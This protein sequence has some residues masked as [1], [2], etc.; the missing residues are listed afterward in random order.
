MS[1]VRAGIA[2]PEDIDAVVK[3]GFGLRT[4]FLG[5]LETADLAC[6]DLTHDVH[7]HVFPFLE[8]SAT[9][10]EILET[11]LQNRK[12]G[13][14]SLEGFHKWSAEDVHRVIKTHDLVLLR[15]RS[16]L[17]KTES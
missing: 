7:D 13:E 16:S 1:L 8:N 3:F 10:L 9:P 12:L 17:P 14:K 6:L 2:S 4:I 15:L 11:K 5:P